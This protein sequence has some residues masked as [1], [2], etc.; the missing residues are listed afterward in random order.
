MG[1]RGPWYRLEITMG[2]WT[3]ARIWR[4]GSSTSSLHATSQYLGRIPHS[5]IQLRKI[6]C[7]CRISK[8]LLQQDLLTRLVR[9]MSGSNYHHPPLINSWCKEYCFSFYGNR[10]LTEKPLRRQGVIYSWWRRRELFRLCL[11]PFG[12]AIAIAPA[13]SRHLSIERVAR[14]KPATRGIHR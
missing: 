11:H 2:R 9:L 14:L 7:L 4:T 5:V 1:N 13:L 8:E 6:A 10:Y 3:L 12:V